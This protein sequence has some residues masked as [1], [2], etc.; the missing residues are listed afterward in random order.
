MALDLWF[1]I[2]PGPGLGV[3][4]VA[5]ASLIAEL[6]G[7]LL[8][9][10]L[11]REALAPLRAALKRLAN[12]EALRRT[13]SASRD[14]L[15]R[16]VILQVS[17]TTFVFLGARFGDTTVAAN[18]ILLQFL[19]IMAF[20]LD[21]LAFAAESLVSQAMGAKGP[22][23][24]NGAADMSMQ[25]GC[26]GAILLA[27]AL[28]LGGTLAINLM[29]AAPDVSGHKRC[30]CCPGG[31]LPPLIGTAA[32]IHD[33][34]LNGALMTHIMR[35][36]AIVAASLIRLVPTLGNQGFWAGHLLV[37]AARGITL[38]RAFPRVLARASA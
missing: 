36:A 21:G 35:N 12:P 14:I 31:S 2:G 30:I 23:S 16:T 5:T 24:I 10:Y 17:L 13:L 28:A 33:G 6:T 20:A 7:L 15:I 38:Y 1:V 19:S 32:W 29:T 9:L 3:A 37:N 27:L 25:W 34:I 4:G 8:A 18:P 22:N 26:G 11:A